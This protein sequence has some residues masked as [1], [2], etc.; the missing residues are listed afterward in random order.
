MGRMVPD[1]NYITIDTSREFVCE[2]LQDVLLQPRLNILKWSEITKQTPGLR[3][4][5]PA[6]HLA[7]LLTG[8][9]GKRTA[10]RGDDLSDGTEVKGCNRID[11][12]DT[13][14]DCKGK[15]S[16]SETFCSHCGSTRI[17]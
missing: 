12:L 7:S 2:F 8:V 13:C 1:S 16:R 3:V 10:A 11:Q 4:G 6:Q 15:V 14:K 9:E 17:D 5:Y